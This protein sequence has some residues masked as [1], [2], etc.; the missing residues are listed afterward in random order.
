[1]AHALGGAASEAVAGAAEIVRTARLERIRPVP[2]VRPTTPA[3][4]P[5]GDMAFLDLKRHPANPSRFVINSNF[6]RLV[7]KRR[8]A[9]PNFR[10]TTD[11]VRSN[12]SGP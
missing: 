3:S 10:D 4:K 8:D 9:H 7:A 11:S 1:M 5:C 6:V 12:P 2:T